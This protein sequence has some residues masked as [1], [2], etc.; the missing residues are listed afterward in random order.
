MTRL[1]AQVVAI[2]LTAGA[3]GAQT[4]GPAPAAPGIAITHAWARATA[5]TA[6]SGAAYLTVTDNAG[7]PDR[8]VGAST[9]V[10]GS[11]ELHRSFEEDGVMK[12]R[13]AGPIALEPGKT[14]TFAPGGL[15]VMLL[16]LAHPLKQGDSFPLTLTFEHSAPVTVEVR[17]EQAGAV[18]ATDHGSHDAM[19]G[20]MTMPK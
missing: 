6:Q 18:G 10:A 2:C 9:P 17:I 1:L 20:G 8:L 14:V 11:A 7:T 13:P 5:A 4:P 12:M 19:H 16:Q 3:A 15:H